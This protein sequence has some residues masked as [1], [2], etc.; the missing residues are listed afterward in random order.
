MAGTIGIYA[1]RSVDWHPL[2]DSIRSCPPCAPKGG[3]FKWF[4]AL[5]SPSVTPPRHYPWTHN[6]ICEMCLAL[7]LPARPARRAEPLHG[8]RRSYLHIWAA[9]GLPRPAHRSKHCRGPPTGP[10]HLRSKHCIHYTT[11]LMYC[12]QWGH[13]KTKSEHG[14]QSTAWPHGRSATHSPAWPQARHRFSLS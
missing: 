10:H 4:R 12:P 2:F 1:M 5:S 9:Q 14:R 13:S 8:F 11:P 6:P 7:L 3:L